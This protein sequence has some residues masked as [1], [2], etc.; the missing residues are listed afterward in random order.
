MQN[1]LS[2]SMDYYNLS[3]AQKR[4]WD[5]E[6]VHPNTPMENIGGVVIIK[7]Q[8]HLT[9]VKR[10]INLFIMR[11]EGIRLRFSEIEGEVVQY[12]NPY[13]EE[14]FDYIDFSNNENAEEDFKEWSQKTFSTPFE[15]EDSNL[16]YLGIFKISSEKW[17]ILLRIHHIICDGWGTSIIQKSV[18]ET[19]IKLLKGEEIDL[20]PAPSFIDFLEKE[21][22][23]LNSPQ[24]LNDKEYWNTKFSNITYDFLYKSTDEYNGKRK[25]FKIEKALAKKMKYFLKENKLSINTFFLMLLGLYLR[26]KSGKKDIIVG[27]PIFNRFTKK[28]RDTL[29]M[30]ISKMPV[31]LNIEDNKTISEF[32]DEINLEIRRDLYHQRYPYDELVKDLEISK[33]GFTSLY[34]YSINYYNTN[35]LRDLGDNATVEALEY[36][37]G[38]QNYSL[39]VILKEI[40]EDDLYMSYDYRIAEYSED[41]INKMHKYMMYLSESIINNKERLIKEIVE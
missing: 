9:L 13:T 21:E 26:N 17:G 22:K 5:I 25:V 14:D 31:R 20:N 41:E 35:Y 11:N 8:L 15:L 6:K 16:Y 40:A 38:T 10:A 12:I 36:Y 30:C 37:N 24:Y 1:N 23:Y 4:A 19:Y 7:G 29:G 34:R 33:Y 39:Q 3:H 27:N 18:L 28:D 2:L 32:I